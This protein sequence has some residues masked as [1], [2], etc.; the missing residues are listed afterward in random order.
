M[1]RWPDGAH[2]N[3]GGSSTIAIRSVCEGN[4]HQTHTAGR[5][6]AKKKII[7]SFQD[8]IFWHTFT[9]TCHDTLVYPISGN[10]EESPL[11]WLVAWGQF[12]RL[13]ELMRKSEW[14]QQKQDDFF[15]RISHFHQAGGTTTLY[16]HPLSNQTY[17]SV[18]YVFPH[19]S[20]KLYYNYTKK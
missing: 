6:D 15:P 9:F 18:L 2:D 10:L 11:R 4:T 16:N 5:H 12:L 20:D 17:F 3:P 8:C 7:I 19:P 14:I 13:Q 1:N